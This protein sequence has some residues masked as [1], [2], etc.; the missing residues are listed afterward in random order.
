MEKPEVP[1]F[2]AR[3]KTIIRDELSA[4]YVERVSQT[5]RLNDA[6][7]YFNDNLS[8]PEIANGIRTLNKV[9]EKVKDLD[10]RIRDLQT[11]FTSIVESKFTDARFNVMIQ[12]RIN[13]EGKALDARRLWIEAWK[14]EETNAI[15]MEDLWFVQMANRLFGIDPKDVTFTN[16]K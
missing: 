4:L 3:I 16:H 13:E 11:E 7:K 9:L 6:L 8:K 2:I 10:L 14:D 1:I 5:E 12:A 15:D